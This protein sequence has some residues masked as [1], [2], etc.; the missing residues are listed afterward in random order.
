MFDNSDGDINATISTPIGTV[1]VN[2]PFTAA[3]GLVGLD[4]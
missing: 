3:P 4:G 2:K 1:T